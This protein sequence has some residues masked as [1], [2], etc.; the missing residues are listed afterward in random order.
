MKDNVFF[1]Y[2]LLTVVAFKVVN[3]AQYCGLNTSTCVNCY[4]A[5][6]FAPCSVCKLV[7]PHPPACFEF[8]RLE[9]GREQQQNSMEHQ[10]SC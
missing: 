2:A 8:L 10:H 6:Q 5:L 7:S 1:H 9:V 4:A 3:S